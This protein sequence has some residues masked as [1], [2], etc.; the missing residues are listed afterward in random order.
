MSEGVTFYQPNQGNQ[1]LQVYTLNKVSLQLDREEWKQLMK[2]VIDQCD[3]A[4]HITDKYMKAILLPVL[5]QIYKNMV[6]KLHNLKERKNN[7]NLSLPEA[8][9][10]VTALLELNSES[11][12]VIEIIRIID[13]KLT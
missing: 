4:Q 1:S 7:L 9:V 11:Y 10:L 2:I 3:Q 12:L 5:K 6:V 13:Q 8:S